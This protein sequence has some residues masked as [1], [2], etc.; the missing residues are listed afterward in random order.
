MFEGQILEGEVALVRIVLPWDWDGSKLLES[1]FSGQDLAGEADRATKTPRFV[2]VDQLDVI[3]KTSVDAR[4]N[5]VLPLE[6]TGEAGRAQQY[7]AVYSSTFLRSVRQGCKGLLCSSCN[8][9]K[10]G[11]TCQ[12]GGCGKPGCAEER[13]GPQA[14]E[15][16]AHEEPDNQAHRGIHNIAGL[17]GRS[18]VNFLKDALVDDSAFRRTPYM[19]IAW[20]PPGAKST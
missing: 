12:Q 13:C 9:K 3:D 15:I 5:R 17:K 7:F 1:A 6:L 2:S 19:S 10:T 20:R 8:C 18:F 16:K 11:T 4:L 14:F